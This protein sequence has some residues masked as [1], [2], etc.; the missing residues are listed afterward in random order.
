MPSGEALRPTD[1][2]E[3]TRWA[4][5]IRD[6]HQPSLDLAVRR[7]LSSVASRAEPADA[8]VDAVIALESLFGTGS[9][10]VGFRVSAAVAWLLEHDKKSRLSRQ[11]SVN[12]LYGLRS[13]IVHG[14][15][16][17]AT[18][19]HER[20]LEACRVATDSIRQLLS[21]Y[22]ELVG[23]GNQRGKRLILQATSGNG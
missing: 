6:A 23:A 13:N 19:L 17:P 12:A 14:Q 16:I 7:T 5:I 18:E 3:L 8:L 15:H 11:K 21:E 1:E 2:E 22:P 9:S 10:E 20:R 4:T